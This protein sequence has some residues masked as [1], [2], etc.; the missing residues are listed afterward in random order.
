[1]HPL[2]AGAFLSLESATGKESAAQSAE[3]D[4]ELVARHLET[5]ALFGETV[6]DTDGRYER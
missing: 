4:V 5:L 1:V 2:A 3:T 6:V